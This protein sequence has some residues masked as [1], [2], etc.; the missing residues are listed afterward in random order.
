MSEPQIAEWIEKGESWR[1]IDFCKRIKRSLLMEIVYSA[2]QEH[3]SLSPH[4]K[5]KKLNP[6]QSCSL[7]SVVTGKTRQ[8]GLETEDWYSAFC[9]HINDVGSTNQSGDK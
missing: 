4:D 2:Y 9:L 6:F 3:R 8:L 1:M 7:P 5:M